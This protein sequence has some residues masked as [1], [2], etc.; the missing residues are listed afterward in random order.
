MSDNKSAPV[1]AG[2]GMGS[3]IAGLI[4]WS[5][6]HSLGWTILHV[7]AGWFYVIYSWFKGRIHW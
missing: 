4:S 5:Y 6:T 2:I 7:F 3:I 1:T